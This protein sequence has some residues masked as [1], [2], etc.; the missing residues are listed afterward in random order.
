MPISA[1]RLRSLELDSISRTFRLI[2]M[3]FHLP[4]R[5]ASLDP[6]RRG[7]AVESGICR[8]WLLGVLLVA[9][10]TIWNAPSAVASHCGSYVISNPLGQARMIRG[11]SDLASVSGE[12]GSSETAPHVPTPCE[13]GQCRSHT[14][15][16]FAPPSAPPVRPIEHLWLQLTDTARTTGELP[17]HFFSEL[18]HA[19]AGFYRE[20]EQPPDSFAS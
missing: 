5:T 16:P 8:S 7:F 20:L 2:S 19:R 10:A 4:T 9:V 11:G 15:T 12:I 3:L 13:R 6:V 18:A 1:R 14:P 17:S